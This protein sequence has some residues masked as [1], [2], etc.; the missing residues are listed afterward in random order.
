MEK[1]ILSLDQGTTSSRAI[2]F[3][4]KGESVHTVQKEFT[5]IFPEPGWVE[6][7]ANEIWGSVLAV[8]AGVLAESG[9]Q[10]AQ[11]EAIGITNQRET[12]VVWDKETGEPIYNAIV[13]QSRQTSEICDELKAAGHN[14]LF[15]EKTG[16][17]IDAYFSGTKVKWIL[18]NVD[19]AREKADNGQLLFGTIDS[20]LIWKLS[21]GKAHVTD[22]TNASRTLMFNIYDLKWDEELLDILGVPASMLPEVKPSSE[23]YAHTVDYHFF[24]QGVPIAGVAGDQQ[25]ALFGQACFEEGMAKN[26]YGTGCFMLMN[27]G[28]KAVKSEH[29]LLTTIA[30]GIDGK[31]QYAL[32]GSI[33]VAGSA[34]QWLRDGMRM[35]QHAKDSED[36]AVKV[37][38]TDGVYV[39]PAFVGL[40]TPYWDS[41]VRGATF[42]LTRGTTKEHF[43][44]ATLE[45][46]A[47]QSKDVL[48]AMEADSAIELKALRVDGGAVHNNFLMQFQA[49]ILNVPVERPNIS[50][51]TAL[52]A[53]YLAGLAVGYWKDKEEISKQWAK[54][55]G[56]IP[57]MKE[58]KR[59][60]L[61]AG[62]KKA[63]FAA[64]AFK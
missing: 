6:H 48:S 61:Y 17:L 53:A 9:V 13:W 46:L 7:N 32:E 60:Q 35:I 12:A 18:D 62:W 37:D 57:E 5:Q 38:S 8:L 44:R 64:T 63:I 39:V 4:K 2:L 55:R 10:P 14:D 11:V 47:Y 29:G 36:Y 22:Y 19:G 26:T 27:T 50:E 16:L 25:A 1:Y 34:I 15:R 56:F 58:E 40:G 51:T 41:D 45:S 43:I 52:G 30:W 42:G 28:E 21:G 33:F 31:V 54:E 24:G 23:V 49:D 3:N 59:E 20:W